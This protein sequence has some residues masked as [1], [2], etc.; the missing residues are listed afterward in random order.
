MYNHLQLHGWP[1]R[2]ELSSKN[3]AEL[4][5]DLAEGY[6]SYGNKSTGFHDLKHNASL[7]RNLSADELKQVVKDEG[8]S[9]GAHATR[10]S[11]VVKIVEHIF[12]DVL[13]PADA[14]VSKTGQPDPRRQ[15]SFI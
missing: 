4:I 9:I 3:R 5:A 11:L 10:S 1:S 14:E 13:E 7:V 15:P 8:I 6:I 12:A 2:G